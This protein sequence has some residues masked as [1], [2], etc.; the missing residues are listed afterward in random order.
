LDR[1]WFRS[2]ALRQHGLR[3]FS[4][5]CRAII[6]QN[7]F[8]PHGLAMRGRRLVYTQGV[9]M[10]SLCWPAGCSSSSAASPTAS[11]PSTPSALSWL[12]RSHRAGMVAHWKRVRGPGWYKSMFVNGLGAFATGVTVII[13]LIAKFTEGAW[14]TLVLIPG[15]ILMMR[16]VKRHYERVAGEISDS[17]RLNT[18][19]MAPPLVVITIDRWS[20]IT[21]NALR[22]ALAISPDVRAVHVDDGQ[23]S[24]PLAS[25]GASWSTSPPARPG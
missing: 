19:G 6:A 7:G 25:R 3:R 4:A 11:F 8:L 20:L 15:L 22:F 2:G 12:S 23:E 1:F 16:T 24:D 5:P 9:Y 18:A 13:V 10:R 14:I 17:A 21:Q